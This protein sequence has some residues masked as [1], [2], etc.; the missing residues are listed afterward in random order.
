MLQTTSFQPCIC[1][2]IYRDFFFFH[3]CNQNHFCPRENQVLLGLLIVGMSATVVNTFDTI[4][5]K[6]FCLPQLTIFL[7]MGF[8]KESLKRICNICAR[9]SNCGTLWFQLFWK[10][11]YIPKYRLQK[12]HSVGSQVYYIRL[13]DVNAQNQSRLK[14]G[15]YWRIYK[16][17][18][19]RTDI[20]SFSAGLCWE[21]WGS[22]RCWMHASSAHRA[23]HIVLKGRTCK[24]RILRLWS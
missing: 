16:V 23:T 4:Y 10:K 17:E 13:P 22:C 15:Q 7:S 3:I 14:L 9:T 8:A 11:P 1:L 21:R 20:S 5:D 12:S 19:L 24:K 6:Y 18:F 2:T